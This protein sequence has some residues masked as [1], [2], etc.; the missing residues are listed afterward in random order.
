MTVAIEAIGSTDETGTETANARLAARRAEA[1]VAALVAGGL[2]RRLFA[3][4][5]GPA[6]GP[7]PD[8]DQRARKRRVHLRVRLTPSAEAGESGR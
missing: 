6:T 2:D 1:V 5:A 7:L 8:E 4:T 3:I